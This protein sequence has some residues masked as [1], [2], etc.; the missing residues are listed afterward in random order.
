LSGESN[1]GNNPDN[2]FSFQHILFELNQN[3]RLPVEQAINTG[4]RL[5]T[6][7]NKDSSGMESAGM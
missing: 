2:S 3:L 4:K 7:D 5:Y 6:L 1:T